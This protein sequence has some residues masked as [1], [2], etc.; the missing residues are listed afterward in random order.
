MQLAAEQDQ[1]APNKS[2]N[3]KNDEPNTDARKLSSPLLL[4]RSHRWRCI[5]NGKRIG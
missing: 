1:Y 3:P 4:G 5:G 2:K